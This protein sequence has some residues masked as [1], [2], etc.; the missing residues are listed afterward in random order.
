MSFT[1]TVTLRKIIAAHASQFSMPTALRQNSVVVASLYDKVSIDTYMNLPPVFKSHPMAK[2]TVIGSPVHNHPYAYQI[3]KNM[4]EL[5]NQHQWR[6]GSFTELTDSKVVRAMFASVADGHDR[7]AAMLSTS[8]SIDDVIMNV[9][10]EEEKGLDWSA[11]LY[12]AYGQVKVHSREDDQDTTIRMVSVRSNGYQ[13][14]YPVCAITGAPVM[15][16]MDH[17]IYTVTNTAPQEQ[18][19]QQDEPENIFAQ[20]SGVQLPQDF[21]DMLSYLLSPNGSNARNPFQMQ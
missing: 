9:F 11:A 21:M 18:Q 14:R 1:K 17:D 5:L 10:G 6:L 2:I 7:L 4:A 8:S 20:L 16:G 19:E 15:E 13:T 3:S 12:N